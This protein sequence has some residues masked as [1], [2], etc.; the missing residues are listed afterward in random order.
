MDK[1]W[2]PQLH[3]YICGI[4]NAK[5]HK[6]IIVNSVEDHVHIFIGLTPKTA[7]SDLVRDIKN[8]S[9]NFVYEMKFIK[10]S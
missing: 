7:I 8:N 10:I 1:S 9:T 4:I 3:K 5:G 2:R 6:P